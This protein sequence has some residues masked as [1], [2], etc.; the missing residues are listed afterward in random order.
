[1][2][3]AGAEG[4]PVGPGRNVLPWPRHASRVCTCR[5]VSASA[6]CTLDGVK[7]GLDDARGVGEARVVLG[8]AGAGG[9]LGAP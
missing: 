8:R 3:D 9:R 7:S 5:R 4:L 2:G 1:M 6:A